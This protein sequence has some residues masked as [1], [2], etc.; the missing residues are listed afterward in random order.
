MT[1][2]WI[3]A[4][5]NE[6][7]STED[8]TSREGLRLRLCL[9]AATCF[10]TFDG[11]SEYAS[12]LSNDEDFS[13]AIQCAIIVHNSTPSSLSD[14]TSSYL[15]RMLGRHRRILYDLE[16][17]FSESNPSGFGQ[18]KLSHAGAY[19]LALARVGLDYRNSGWHVLPRPNSQ[20]VSCVT[21]GGKN[22]HY[23]LLTG[24]LLID[25][26]QMGR[27]PREIVEHPTYASILGTV[28]DLLA[29]LFR[30]FLRSFQRVLDVAPAD[31]P[32]IDYMTRYT[33]SGYQVRL[34]SLFDIPIVMS[35]TNQRSYCR[36]FQP[37][38]RAD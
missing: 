4:I 15:T 6:L 31:V 24:Q 25:G 34:Y 12:L 35:K 22:I 23:D 33:V 29:P 32:G 3:C 9:L 27:L 21:E 16:H 36:G 8:E 1:H 37:G 38:I 17:I 26:K 30:P 20:W 7:E 18:A 28:S 13:I 10:S 2:R 19:D 11:C 5:T 14:N